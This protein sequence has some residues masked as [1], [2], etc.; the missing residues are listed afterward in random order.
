MSGD[1]FRGG[2]RVVEGYGGGRQV[3]KESGGDGVRLWLKRERKRDREGSNL[4]CVC[5]LS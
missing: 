3:V 4:L 2:E 1:G 5:V